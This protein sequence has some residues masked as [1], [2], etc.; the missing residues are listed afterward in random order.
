ML[1]LR[2]ANPRHTDSPERGADT[3]PYRGGQPGFL[4]FEDGGTIARLGAQSVGSGPGA[5]VPGRGVCR[6]RVAPAGNDPQVVRE[7]LDTRRTRLGGFPLPTSKGR[8]GDSAR[9]GVWLGRHI[10]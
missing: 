5:G 3:E 4:V 1:T 6:I 2:A 10:C 9:W 8:V 7:R